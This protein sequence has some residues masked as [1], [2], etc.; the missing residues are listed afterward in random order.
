MSDCAKTWLSKKSRWSYDAGTVMFCGPT[1]ESWFRLNTPKD[2]LREIN[3]AFCE[4]IY[5]GR[6]ESKE[7]RDGR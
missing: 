1:G 2:I 7:R 6:N 3:F 5:V 4:G